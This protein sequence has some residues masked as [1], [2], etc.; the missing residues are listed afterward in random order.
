MATRYFGCSAGWNR[1][2]ENNHLR[3]TWENRS[4]TRCEQRGTYV[5]RHRTSLAREGSLVHALSYFPTFRLLKLLSLKRAKI[6]RKSTASST[7]QFNF[8]LSQVSRVIAR[9]VDT[10]IS[11]E[12]TPKRKTDHYVDDDFDASREDLI[13]IIHADGRDHSSVS[14]VV[15]KIYI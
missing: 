1:C 3:H 8:S 2:Q 4:L 10:A 5:L 12:S 14:R 9:N 13:S 11:T 7:A 15:W 6:R